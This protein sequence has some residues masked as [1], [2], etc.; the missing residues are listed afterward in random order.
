MFHMCMCVHR[1]KPDHLVLLLLSIKHGF[2]DISINW[3]VFV[4]FS[5]IF[6]AAFHSMIED[7]IM[8]LITYDNIYVNKWDI[9]K[10]SHPQGPSGG[11]KE[12]PSHFTGPQPFNFTPTKRQLLLPVSCTSR[13]W[14]SMHTDIYLYVL[15]LME[16]TL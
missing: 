2:L 3:N 16:R 13:L 12:W 4:Y 15:F 8:Y 5:H 10:A 6:I 7:I 9:H 1:H 11:W 14:Y